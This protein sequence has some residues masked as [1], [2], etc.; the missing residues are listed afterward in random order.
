[1]SKNLLFAISLAALAFGGCTDSTSQFRSAVTGDSCT[2]DVTTIQ[3]E[4]GPSKKDKEYCKAKSNNGHGNNED[5]VDSSNP[6][7]G[8]GGPNGETDQSCDG[9]GDCIDDEI[10]NGPGD[11]TDEGCELPPGCDESLCC[12][13]DF[14]DDDGDGGGDDGGISLPPASDPTCTATCD[15]DVQCGVESSCLDGCCILALE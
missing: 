10:H 8:S 3:Y 14:G 7:G 13:P 15:S 5:G 11:G 12:D 6:G 2:P 1:M 9:T 4:G